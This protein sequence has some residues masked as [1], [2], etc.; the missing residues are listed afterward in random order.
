MTTHSYL[1][2]AERA[3]QVIEA[4]WSDPLF[5]QAL[6]LDAAQALAD[7]FDLHLPTGITLEVV[8]E[9]AGAIWLV[10]PPEGEMPLSEHPSIE[11]Q[12]VE[13]AGRE[14]VF[15]AAL[16]ENPV[17]ILQH[18]FD[19][20]LPDGMRV[21]LLE[22]SPTQRY[23]VLPLDPFA[24]H[25][26]HELDEMELLAVAGGGRTYR[27]GEI[28][29]SNGTPKTRSMAAAVNTRRRARSC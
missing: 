3:Q 2:S 14:P 10:L 1:F 17:A 28:G 24:A 18:H 20:A 26:P 23:F 19:M 6:L 15:R 27:P 13:R 7:R 29:A 22:E 5:K 12:I 11:M 16:R 21:Q 8:E 25:E 9:E 4:A